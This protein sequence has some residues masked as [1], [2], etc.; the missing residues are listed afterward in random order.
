MFRS[1]EYSRQV[2]KAVLEELNPEEKVRE[3]L[4]EKIF[5]KNLHLFAIGKASW[6][7]ANGAYKHLGNRI[8]SGMVIT[9]YGHSE[10]PIGDFRI[11]EAGHPIPDENSLRA[12]RFA[13]EKFSKLNANDELLLLISGGGSALFEVLYEEIT[14]EDLQSVTQKLM[15]SGMGIKEINALRKRLS[16]VKGGQFAQIVAPASVQALIISDVIGDNV[17]NIASGPVTEETEIPQLT[18]ILIKLGI[19][20][21]HIVKAIQRELPKGIKNVQV[22]IIDNVVNACYSAKNN[23]EALGLKASILTTCLECEAKEAGRFISA[24]IKDIYHGNSDLSKPHCLIFGGETVVTLRGNGKGGR[25][26]ELALSAAIELDGLNQD[27]TIFS[28]G[29]DGTDGP[30]EAAGGI[31]N[32]DTI[33]HMKAAGID[34]Q[35]ML[36]NNDSYHALQAANAL[37]QTGP[38]G[39]NVNDLI[40]AVLL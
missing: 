31:V 10:G 8:K 25:N 21:K 37:I 14:L 33:S 30:T 5:K 3:A 15:A 40:C 6:N 2:I 32:P 34:A 19:D 38:T 20:D 9:K 39:T 18:D 22:S 29:T 13:I 28:L 4:S 36:Q 27:C 35:K 16:R 11:F 1:E 7:M 26:Q 12:G 23:F 24:L 17:S